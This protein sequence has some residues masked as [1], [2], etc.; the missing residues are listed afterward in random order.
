[1]RLLSSLSL[2]HACT[3]LPLLANF[4][5]K[6]TFR[7]FNALFGR[8]GRA[9]SPD[10]IV[11]LFKAKCLPALYYGSEVCPVNKTVTKSLQYVIKS[12]F[13]KIFQTGSDNVIAECM[14]MFNCLPVADAIFRRKNFFVTV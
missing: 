1:L 4:S 12:C 8:V 2:A 6:S 13:S 10:V 7:A 9:T 11:Q 5:N 14:N 3:L